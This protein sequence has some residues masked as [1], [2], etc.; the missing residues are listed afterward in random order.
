MIEGKN[1][2]LMPV[3]DMVMEHGKVTPTRAGKEKEEEDEEAEAEEKVKEKEKEK[4]NLERA[5]DEEKEIVYI[6]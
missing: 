4:E 2:T 5:K 3:I 1:V 6:G